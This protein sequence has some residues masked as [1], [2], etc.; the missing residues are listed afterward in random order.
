[1]AGAGE[2]FHADRVTRGDIAVEELIV[3]P[4]HY[5]HTASPN[6]LDNA[7]VSEDLPD[8]GGRD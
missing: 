4:I 2:H 5:T 7:V 3:S 8:T 1:M 6:L